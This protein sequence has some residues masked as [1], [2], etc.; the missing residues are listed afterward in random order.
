MNAAGPHWQ[1]GPV[2]WS[3]GPVPWSVGPG[4]PAR[5][6]HWHHH[7]HDDIRGPGPVRPRG[8][9]LRDWATL[10]LQKLSAAALALALAAATEIMP[11]ISEMPAWVP[12][13]HLEPCQCYITPSGYCITPWL[14]NTIG[15]VKLQCYHSITYYKETGRCYI[16]LLY[17]HPICKAD[18][19]NFVYNISQF[20]Y[21][22]GNMYNL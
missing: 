9:R 3:V 8:V 15:S 22:I 19:C 6:W 13:W 1:P 18:L 2:P 21:N 5:Q 20:L 11:V 7:H 12:A 14:Y 16:T 17:N 4:P 10:R